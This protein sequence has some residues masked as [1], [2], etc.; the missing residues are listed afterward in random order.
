MP[1]FCDGSAVRLQALPRNG[2]G[3]RGALRAWVAF[4]LQARGSDGFERQEN[5]SG[6]EEVLHLSADD[7][8]LSDG[9][10]PTGESWQE[11]C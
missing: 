5:A 4:E 1:G 3:V 2:L 7:L 8:L 9:T 11:A 10:E 6:S